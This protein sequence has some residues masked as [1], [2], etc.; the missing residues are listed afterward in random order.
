M[1]SGFDTTKN[2]CQKA[3]NDLKNARHEIEHEDAA[4]DTVCF[5]SQQTVEKYLKA[6]LVYHGMDIPRTHTL[7]QNIGVAEKVWCHISEPC[8]DRILLVRIKEINQ[9]LIFIAR[10]YKISLH[11]G[12]TPVF[13]STYVLNPIK[14]ES[15]DS[16]PYGPTPE[17]TINVFIS[18]SSS[19][20]TLAT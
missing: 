2:W 12:L 11:A 6:F 16:I 19:R 14:Q 5:H 18:G 9:G 1:S 8:D 3:D 17:G 15:S 13:G 4:L 20:A 7:V 10:S